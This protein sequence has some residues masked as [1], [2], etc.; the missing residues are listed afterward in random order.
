VRKLVLTIFIAMSAAACA[1]T[2]GASGGEEAPS[3]RVRPADRPI[4]T[5]FC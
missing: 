5:R 4:G 2:D 1:S 3:E